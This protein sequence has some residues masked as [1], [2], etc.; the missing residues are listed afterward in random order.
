MY[1]LAD[2]PQ[3]TTP[4]VHEKGAGS[5]KRSGSSGK[6]Q[7]CREGAR[8]WGR[9]CDRQRRRVKAL[10]AGSRLIA[11]TLQSQRSG[12]TLYIIRCMLKCSKTPCLVRDNNTHILRRC[13]PE[14]SSQR[15]CPLFALTP[16]GPGME[17]SDKL[18][19]DPIRIVSTC[20]QY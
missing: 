14:G 10:K 3:R 2:N 13:L 9:Y 8:A 16:P 15:E 7:C 6:H 20:L 17:T 4:T 11:V 19:G 5:G 18:S 12:R 1:R